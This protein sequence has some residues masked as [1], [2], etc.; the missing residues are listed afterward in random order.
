[1]HIEVMKMN[2][3]VGKS[4]GG[5]TEASEFQIVAFDPIGHKVS[6]AFAEE[7]FSLRSFIS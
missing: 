1:M 7:L 3:L 6:C 5:S 4:K 2:I